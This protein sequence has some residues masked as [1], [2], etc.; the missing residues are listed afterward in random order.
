M[1]QKRS[2]QRWI[3]QIKHCFKN[4]DTESVHELA[5]STKRRIDSIRSNYLPEKRSFFFI[6]RGGNKS[7]LNFIAELILF[8]KKKF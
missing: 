2:I 6:N 4:V 1:N 5:E 8:K 7:S 3:K